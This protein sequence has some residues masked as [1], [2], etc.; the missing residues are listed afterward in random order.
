MPVLCSHSQAIN[1][2]HGRV[3]ELMNLKTCCLQLEPGNEHAFCSNS[4]IHEPEDPSSAVEPGD[5]QS[6]VITSRNESDFL[7]DRA[8]SKTPTGQV[9]GVKICPGV[10][11]HMNSKT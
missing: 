3:H 2:M 11:D 5:T 8:G 6:L 4:C 10:H 9:H 7:E 1:M